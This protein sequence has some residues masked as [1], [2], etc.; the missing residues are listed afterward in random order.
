MCDLFLLVLIK[1]GPLV[2]LVVG[3]VNDFKVMLTIFV[4]QFLVQLRNFISQVLV[5]HIARMG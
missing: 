2:L 3:L 1:S 5:A 4:L